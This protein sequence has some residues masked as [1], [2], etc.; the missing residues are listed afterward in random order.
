MKNKALIVTFH[1]VPN[2]GAVLQAYALQKT[3]ECFCDEVKILD[4]R[5]KGL[6]SS[7][8]NISTSNLF[9][10]VKS[11][12]NLYPYLKKKCRFS[13][14]INRNLN[15][16]D[17]R[18][19]NS[20]DIYCNSDFV[21]LGSDQIWN[22]DI[23]KHLDPVYFGMFPKKKETVI[24]SYAASIG[25]VDLNLSEKEFV[26]SALNDINYIS[27]REKE[28]ENLL[29]EFISKTISVDVD[30]TLLAEPGVFKKFVKKEK[31]KPYVLL[32]SLNGRKELFSLAY[33]ISKYLN[34]EL[35]ELSGVRKPISKTD[36]KTIYDAGPEEFITYIY[37]ADFVITDS[38]HGCVFSI[39]FHIPFVTM[40]Y[41]ER[42][43]RIIN[44]LRLSGLENRNIN[45]F[46]REILYEDINWEN[47]DK[48]I[49][50]N[51]IK[52]IDYIRKVT[53]LI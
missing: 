46:N 17:L 36:H 28:A 25:K 4:Y 13:K 18:Y 35:I 52:S 33:K 27:V 9:S 24:A 31:R 22:P 48:M 26:I 37:N 47:V 20:N 6:F 7:Y 42:S 39:L 15:L 41:Q 2:Y 51:R 34:L 16:S 29:K 40:P 49:D 5:P 1:C 19:Y 50:Q 3:L 14:F 32:Y 12:Y 11:I 8:K 44:L 45:N 30:P 53:A 10:F 38:F 23:L 21:F 43:S